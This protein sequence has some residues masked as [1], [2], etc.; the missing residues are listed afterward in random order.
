VARQTVASAAMTAKPL[1]RVLDSMMAL[2]AECNVN[3]QGARLK[4][5]K[6]DAR[7]SGRKSGDLSHPRLMRGAFWRMKSAQ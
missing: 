7:E 1:L 6:D 2:A 3:D 5:E 4:P